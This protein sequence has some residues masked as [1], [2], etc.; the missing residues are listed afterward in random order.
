MF[1]KNF[2]KSGLKF[3][4]RESGQSLLELA[5]FGSLLLM[6]LGVLVGYGLRYNFQQQATMEAFRK[7]QE[8][9]YKDDEGAPRGSASYT[10]IKD[11]HIP[12]PQNPFGVGQVSPIMAS[13]S[14]T[15]DTYM[16][17]LPDNYAGLPKMTMSFEGNVNGQP[18]EQT[19][20]LAT[21]GFREETVLLWG[22]EDWFKNVQAKYGMIFGSVRG[23]CTYDEDYGD[24]C[25]G[26][27]DTIKII[28]PVEGEIV[29]YN[30]AVKQARMIVDM[31][32]FISQ[33]ENIKKNEQ[34]CGDIWDSY[35]LQSPWYVAGAY[36]DGNRWIFPQIENLFV[37]PVTGKQVQA[38]GLQT[39]ST[40]QTNT[41]FSLTK[42][43]DSSEIATTDTLAW[44]TV[45]NRALLYNNH[46]DPV[47]GIAQPT[48]NLETTDVDTTR[49]DSRSFTWETPWQN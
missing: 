29:D 37:Y 6:L 28:D 3:I 47:S 13:A 41:Q 44:S 17:A 23:W 27:P 26:D 30:S 35:P 4:S 34:D 8:F 21:A 5:I 38:M 9:A 32:F 43:E 10:V 31:D 25:Q 33:C 22:N 2:Y 1:C 46:L 42:D 48:V 39:E 18:Q 20:E 14:V 40:Q 16:D 49:S 19:Y 11:R 12:D 15:R 36:Q 7:A 24:E 45:T